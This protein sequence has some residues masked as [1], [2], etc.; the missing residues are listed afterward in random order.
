MPRGSL[1]VGMY[2]DW[3]GV[4]SGI[5]EVA[6]LPDLRDNWDE[7]NESRPSDSNL[8]RKVVAAWRAEFGDRQ[9]KARE[10]LPVIGLLLDID[11]GGEHASETASGSV[12]GG[13]RV[14]WSTD[15]RS[16]GMTSQAA[17]A[18]G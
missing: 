12:S 14:V 11:P 17:G 9:V 7:W 2:E 8:I 4:G 18:G 10:L 13:C 15:S 1:V 3:S 5:A 16:S 6:G